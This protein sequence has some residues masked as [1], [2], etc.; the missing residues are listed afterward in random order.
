MYFLRRAGMVLYVMGNKSR[1]LAASVCVRHGIHAI[2]RLV[3]YST[4]DTFG[5]ERQGW[6]LGGKKKGK[7]K[8]HGRRLRS[9]PHGQGCW[10]GLLGGKASGKQVLIRP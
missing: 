6:D 2:D 8:R 7:R 10:Q 5:K 9:H 3:V 1:A 4:G